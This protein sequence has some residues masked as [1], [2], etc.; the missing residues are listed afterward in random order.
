MSEE[1]DEFDDLYGSKFL[2]ASDVKKPFTATIKEVEK[3]DFARQGERSKVKVVLT[4]KS[5]RKPVVCN[6]TNALS[7]SEEFGKDFDEWVDKRV[8]VQAERTTFAG[9]PTMGI[10]LYPATEEVAPALKAPKKGKPADDP[11]D[12]LPED[13]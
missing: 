4:L 3:Q 2:A 11:N 1:S 7:L 9:K 13:L 8:K 10:R 6:K 12:E 5:V